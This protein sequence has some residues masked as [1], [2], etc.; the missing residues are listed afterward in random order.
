MTLKT[1]IAELKS[2]MAKASKVAKLKIEKI[3]K[4]YE[5]RK[6]ANFK[7]ALN[8]VMALAFPLTLKSGRGDKEYDRVIAKYE[9]AT[10]ATGRIAREI[11]QKSDKGSNIEVI[12][13]DFSKPRTL[14]TI[15]FL[16][17]DKINTEE[18]RKEFSQMIVKHKSRINS[19][20]QKA[21]ENYKSMKIKMRLYLTYEKL[22][23]DFNGHRTPQR[24]DAV[25]ATKQ[26][27]TITTANREKAIDEQISEMSSKIETLDQRDVEGKPMGSGWMIVSIDKLAIDIFE[28]KPLRG[29]SYIETPEKIFQFKMRVNQHQKR[30][31]S[32]L[33]MVHAISSVRQE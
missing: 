2:Y 13:A 30:G 28:T 9:N 15:K 31:R 12:D 25:L 6:I 1:N 3:I 4:L 10:P 29:S 22:T 32:V 26:I 16:N 20:I 19:L 23:E 33:Q 11:E 21:L 14:Y 7:T 17:N 18:D 27:H 24:R 8:T 5:D